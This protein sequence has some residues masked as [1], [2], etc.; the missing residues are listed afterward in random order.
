VLDH[1]RGRT[2]VTA[3][4]GAS[5]LVHD[6]D[7]WLRQV[8]RVA[9]LRRRPPSVHRHEDRVQAGHRPEQVDPLGA[10]RGADRHPVAWAN[11]VASGKSGGDRRGAALDVAEADPPAVAEDVAVAVATSRT[12]REDLA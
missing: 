9:H 1:Q 6:Q 11:P 4:A 5:L 7:R 2:G 10:I 12:G 3:G 8:E